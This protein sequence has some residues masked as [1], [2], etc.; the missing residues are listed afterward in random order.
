MPSLH[1]ETT[2]NNKH[3]RKCS[4]CLVH[5]QSTLY[6]KSL[7]CCVSNLTTSPLKLT[8]STFIL[9][10][11]SQG[12]QACRTRYQM[13]KSCILY[14]HLQLN[15]K[16]CDNYKGTLIQLLENTFIDWL[17]VQL[18]YLA[19]WKWVQYQGNWE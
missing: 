16:Q 5:C 18:F 13:T 2:M 1:M 12:Q 19:F 7:P 4:K 17:L 11:T 8:A 10:Q 6:D 15:G 14:L 9:M 3:T